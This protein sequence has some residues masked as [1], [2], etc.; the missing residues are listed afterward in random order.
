MTVN[1]ESNDVSGPSVAVEVTATGVLN[2][3]QEALQVA[4]ALKASLDDRIGSV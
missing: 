4:G 1:L 2:E 3:Y